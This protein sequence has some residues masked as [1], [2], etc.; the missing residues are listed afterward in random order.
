MKPGTH[1]GGVF[2]NRD[3]D[4]P[5]FD[6]MGRK[7]SYTEYDAYQFGDDPEFP[8]LPDHMKRGK[9][10]FVRDNLGNTYF[11]DDH[12]ETFTLIEAIMG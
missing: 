11:T 12:Y 3:L 2:D 8:H 5:E 6:D 4:L 10:R 9:N 7:L 1:A